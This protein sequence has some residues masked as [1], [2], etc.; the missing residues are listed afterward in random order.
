MKIA[1]MQ[2]GS[3]YKVSDYSGRR[4]R[5]DEVVDVSHRFGKGTIK[6]V[7]CTILNEETGE[8]RPRSEY[9]RETKESHDIPGTEIQKNY[10]AQ[11]IEQPWETYAAE[12]GRQEAE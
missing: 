7:R 2:M 1:D 9:N 3:E 11:D 12:Q 10:R 8:P 4:V 5:A 6:Q